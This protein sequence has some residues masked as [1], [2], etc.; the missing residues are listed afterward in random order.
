MI[1]W[2]FSRAS[3]QAGQN[4]WL[5]GGASL[6]RLLR[7]TKCRWL[8]ARAGSIEKMRKVAGQSISE[9]ASLIGAFALRA[10]VRSFS[11]ERY[12]DRGIQSLLV[13]SADAILRIARSQRDSIAIFDPSI[14]IP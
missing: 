14:E 7:D 5:R 2:I 4:H 3:V 6:A 10:A 12:D 11:F 13:E 8:R 1:A 9:G